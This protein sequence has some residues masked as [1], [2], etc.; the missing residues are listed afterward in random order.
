[1][2]THTQVAE[3][4]ARTGTA[5]QAPD[6]KEFGAAGGEMI[7]YVPCADCEA[8]ANG[9]L[10]GRRAFERF[11]GPGTPGFRGDGV[12]AAPRPWG[13]GYAAETSRGLGRGRG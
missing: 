10:P 6:D 11:G 4:D 13:R 5:L 1:M 7:E 12:A 3:E 8:A 9:T 2:V